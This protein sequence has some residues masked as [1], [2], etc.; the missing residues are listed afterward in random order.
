MIGRMRLT[1]S[2]VVALL[3][4]LQLLAPYLH[5]H[6]GSSRVDGWHLH[7]GA[8]LAPLAEQ[9]AP[10][11]APGVQAVQARVMPSAPSSA[12]AVPGES[13][14]V[15]M[16]AEWLRDSWLP[17][18]PQ[19]GWLAA[20]GPLAVPETGRRTAVEARAGAVPPPFLILAYP[21]AAP[22]VPAITT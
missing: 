2:C 21:A 3:A 14:A 5:A 1:R 11:L 16:P 18:L 20:L 8:A 10:M 6:A 22:P 12:L 19:A 4:L 13:P 15:E 17:V 7:L 9:D